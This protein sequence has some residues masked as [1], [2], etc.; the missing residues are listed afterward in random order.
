MALLE[1]TTDSLPSA[2]YYDP[3]Q[4]ALELEAVWYRD[5]VPVARSDDLPKAGDFVVEKIGD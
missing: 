3:A 5:W 4:Y 2:W 1:R